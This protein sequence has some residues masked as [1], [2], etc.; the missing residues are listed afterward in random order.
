MNSNNEQTVSLYSI[1]VALQSGRTIQV[2]VEAP[3]AVA[4][5]EEARYEAN[6]IAPHDPIRSMNIFHEQLVK[7]TVRVT[8]KGTGSRP[9]PPHR[10]SN[11]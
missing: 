10:K 5:I 3:D 6:Q 7:A 8:L 1:N 11:S 4:A 9:K 2:D